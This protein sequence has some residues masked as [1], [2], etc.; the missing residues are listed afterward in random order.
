[1]GIKMTFSVIVTIYKVE[2]Y[3]RRCVDSILSQTYSDFEL[4]LVDDGSPDGCPAICDE[5]AANDG[6]VRVIHKKN[7]GLVSARNA[8]IA[9]A[10]GEYVCYVDADDWIREDLLETVYQ[11]AVK[12]YEPDMIIFGSVRKYD[13]R[14]E[15]LVDG[16][17]EGLYEKADLKKNVYPYMMYD[18]RL[19]FCKGLI[20]PVAWNKVYK[21]GFL[22]DHYCLDE[23]IRMGEDNAFV[24]E[25]LWN[26]NKVYICSEVLYFYNQTNTESMTQTYDPDRFANNSYLFEY[27]KERLG[28][29]DE[30]L[31]GQLNAFRAY[32]LIMA[33][34]HEIKCGRKIGEATRH[35]KGEINK[36]HTLDDI[37][38]DGLPR[39]ARIYIRL[40]HMHLYR[41]LLIA[42]KFAVRAG[43]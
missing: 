37:R 4:V 1:M 15:S 11:R 6:R 21:I 20:F 17:K 26:A 16:L 2:E 28:G 23:R 8:G 13:D 35:I 7:G 19:P 3:L 42:T 40:L 25:C 43:R 41:P 33:V 14:E 29:K 27:M 10:R 39:S 12:D 18:N 36:Y 5:Y 22:K 31:D 34:F 9:V 24:Y 38:P 30:V 32:W